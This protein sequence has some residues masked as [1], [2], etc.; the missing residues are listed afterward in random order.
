MSLGTRK[1]KAQRKGIQLSVSWA[2]REG[3]FGRC[4]NHL[5]SIIKYLNM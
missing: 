5:L 1:T 2:S 3:V 4:W